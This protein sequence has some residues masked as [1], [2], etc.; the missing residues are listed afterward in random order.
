[1]RR[2]TGRA[3]L[4]A[5][6]EHRGNRINAYIQIA[7]GFAV[8]AIAAGAG[9]RLF[10]GFRSHESKSGT[11]RPGAAPTASS[12]LP[13]VGGPAILIAI[14]AGGIAAVIAG[15]GAAL[16]MSLL[17]G[18]PFFA[19]G[20]A[21][22]LKKAVRGHGFGDGRSM[23]LAAGAATIAAIVYTL[24]PAAES[25]FGLRHWVG[26]GAFGDVVFGFWAF[27]LFLVV[28]VSTGISDGV[29]GL[30]SGLSTIAA[31][32]IAL[33]ATVAAAA[34]GPAWIVAGASAGILVLNLPSSWALRAGRRRR[35]RIYLGDSGALMLGA[36][37]TAA[38]LAAGVDLLLP[39]IGGFLIL[40]GL[41]SVVQA[42][43]LVPFY[44]RSARFGGPER[45][46]IQHSEFP[47]PFVAA[48]FH[49]HLELIGLGRRQV[50]L[51]LW[52][53]AAGGA[54]LALLIAAIGTIPWTVALY[55]VGVLKMAVVWFGFSSL[56]PASLT[57]QTTPD[58][59]CLALVH[60]WRRRRLG[61]LPTLTARRHLLPEGGTILGSIPLD[62]PMNPIVARR[63]FDEAV[64]GF[65]ATEA[66]S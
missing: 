37:L 7:I 43:I 65:D 59:S 5:T 17:A 13:L 64:V 9:L 30:T 45:H 28:A 15:Q 34:A 40:E 55:G 39:L 16:L 6:I 50:V 33:A 23:L 47:L 36:F 20:F 32:G 2:S 62:R 4:R 21:D 53:F 27:V 3:S 22:D 12:R 57:V 42:K 25:P 14:G 60:G 18:L 54:G 35:A 31:V 48:P 63:L 11:Y 49:H 51:L 41:S 66:G 26:P 1:V 8:A 56:R 19:I 38:A 24:A 52:I 10:P 58:G 61:L 44:R 46:S 29:D